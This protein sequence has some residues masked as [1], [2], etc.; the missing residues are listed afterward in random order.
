MNDTRFSGTTAVLIAVASA[1]MLGSDASAQ[2]YYRSSTHYS[3]GG[4][5]YYAPAVSGSYTRTLT[6][7]YAQPVESYRSREVRYVEPA[8]SVTYVEPLRSVTYVEPVVYEA[9]R[10][11]YVPTRRI[12]RR[13]YP[14][15]R[16][17][18]YRSSPRYS[19]RYYSRPRQYSRYTVGRSPRYYRRS[20]GRS[21]GFSLSIGRGGHSRGGGFSFYYRR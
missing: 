3:R 9:P 19:V 17:Y 8:R 6:V 11:R 18:S 5:S 16:Y 21:Y 7:Q 4:Q 20:R 10:I 1:T 14:V 15:R 12:I 13:S 2:E